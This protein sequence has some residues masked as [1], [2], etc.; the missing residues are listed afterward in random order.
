MNTR[1]IDLITLFDFY[2]LSGDSLEIDGEEKLIGWW[3]EK[4]AYLITDQ[5]GEN[6]ELLP[7]DKLAE[8]KEEGHIINEF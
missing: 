1:F 5:N 8:W 3:G 4:N 7:L 6:E 2:A